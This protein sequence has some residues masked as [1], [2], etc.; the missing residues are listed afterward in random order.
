EVEVLSAFKQGYSWLHDRILPQIRDEDVGEIVIRFRRNDPPEAWPQQAI[1][2]P[3][4][5]LHEI[6]PIDE[7][8]A[9]ELDLDLE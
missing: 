1:N 8:L 5:W 4:R 9:R 7:V 6:F 2:T 3:V